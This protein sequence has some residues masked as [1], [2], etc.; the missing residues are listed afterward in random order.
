[1]EGRKFKKISDA[2]P[3][4]GARVR[5]FGLWLRPVSSFDIAMEVR[6]PEVL[7][8]VATAKTARAR[9]VDGQAERAT[10]VRAHVDSSTAQP[11]GRAIGR[12]HHGGKAPGLGSVPAH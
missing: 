4:L 10:R 6:G 2:R 9:V 1:M 7:Y 11:A 5:P 3:A 8:L 12:D